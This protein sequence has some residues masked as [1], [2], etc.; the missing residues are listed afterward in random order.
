MTKA[1]AKLPDL[2]ETLARSRGKKTVA[3]TRRGKR[4]LAVMPWDQY[5]SLV[6]TM[7][8]LSDRPLMRRIRL[9]IKQAD[10]GHFVPLED[11]E[12]RLGL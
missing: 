9:S 12:R 6:E 7:E 8:I 3:I 1:R 11:V 2:P 5:E 10:A 4:V